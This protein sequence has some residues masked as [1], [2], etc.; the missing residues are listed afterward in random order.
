MNR[1]EN[2]DGPPP[3]SE[4]CATD[5]VVVLN[6]QVSPQARLFM[7]FIM[8]KYLAIAA[9]FVSAMAHA[10]FG[11]A[12]YN[13]NDVRRAMPAQTGVVID[14]VSSDIAVEASGVSRAV[15]ATAAGLACGVATRSMSDWASR[16]A[17]IGLC[18]LFG[19]RVGSAFGGETR[20]A[21]TLIVRVDGANVLAVA[22]EDPN[23][24][25]GSRV[26]VLANGGAT[27]VVLA[28]ALTYSRP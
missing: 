23:I 20:K 2:H 9:L 8:K 3:P 6:L 14:V 4:A 13:A 7:E 25:V 26:Y 5:T 24:Q 22:Q 17:V 15:G 19:E 12:D 18:G 1:G 11:G 16:T 21:S 28:S 10:Q 27:R